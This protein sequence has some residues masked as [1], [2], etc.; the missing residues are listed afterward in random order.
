M[1]EFH[2]EHTWPHISDAQEVPEILNSCVLFHRGPLD[3]NFQAGHGLHMAGL[4]TEGYFVRWAGRPDKVW[5]KGLIIRLVPIAIC[6][7][8]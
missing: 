3:D 4:A 5:P 1:F 6:E 8:W 2:T 7:L